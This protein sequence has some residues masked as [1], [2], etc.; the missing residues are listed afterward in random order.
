MFAIVALALT[1]VVVAATRADGRAGSQSASNDGG[2]W[3][4]NRDAGAVGHLNREVLEVSA[5]VRVAEVGA[6]FDID[7]SNDLI[8][9]HDRSVEQVM[10]LD[11][12]T[13]QIRQT[14]AV[15]PDVEVSATDGGVV[16][17]RTSP[18]EVWQLA[19]DEFGAIDDVRDLPPVIT[20]TSGLIAVGEGVTA[21]FDSETSSVIRFT[22][23]FEVGRTRIEGTPSSIGIVGGNAV[24]ATDDDIIEVESGR[25]HSPGTGPYTFAQATP[26]NSIVAVDATDE[27]FVIDPDGSTHSFT[28]ASPTTSPILHE[29][30]VFAITE[31]PTLVR[32]CHPGDSPDGDE[33]QMPL[34]GAIGEL[35]LR[36]VNGWIWVNDLDTGGAW[37]TNADAPLSRIDDW[38][39]ALAEDEIDESDA[40]VEDEGGI[41]EVRLNPD[42]DD[43]Q[44]I[45]ADQQDDDDEND[46]PVARDDKAST[47]VDRPVVVRVL[48]NDEDPDG[49]VLLVDSVEV[50][51]TSTAQVWITSTRDTIQVTP[52]AG[53][54]GTVEFSYLVTDGRGG[55]DR[56]TVVVD[57]TTPSASTNRP[58]EPVTDVATARA[59]SA[60]S[61]NVLTNDTD[62]DGDA[63][64]LLEV[65]AERGHIVFDPSGQVTFTPDSADGQGRIE[66]GYLVSDDFGA[67]AEGRIVVNVR[68]ADANST[69]DARNDSVVT[70]VDNP[71]R[72]N[73]LD[74]DSDPDG[75][76]LIVARQPILT[77]GPNGVSGETIAASVQ[78][79]RDGEFSFV[80]EIA[81]VYLFDYL[82]SDGQNSDTAQIRVDVTDA[83]VN[84]PPVAVRDDVSIPVGGTRLVYVL[85]NDGDPNGDVIDIVEWS[86]AQG[87]DIEPVS[88]V[89]FRVTVGTDAPS[90]STFRY[91]ISDGI[92]EPVATVV[93]VSV[94]DV[95]S[96]NQ[97][98]IVRPD[99]VELR[100][101]RSTTIPVLLNDFDPEGGSLSV[102]RLPA[103]TDDVTYELGPDGQS[104]IVTLA[105]TAAAGFQFGYDVIDTGGATAASIVD[106][107]VI[108]STE[109]NRPP[110][111]RP[112]IGRTVQ[113]RSIS[114]A[115]L[116]NDTDPDGDVVTIESIA[117]QPRNGVA[118]IVDGG[119]LYTPSD[120]FTGTDRFTYVVIDT[121]GARSIGS[122][123]VG[124]TPAARQN[125]APSANDDRIV[126]TTTADL[127]VL[128]NDH[129]P[130]GDALTLVSHTEPS[131][132][133][134]DRRGNSL[135]YTPPVVT[136]TT[137]VSFGYE[138]SDG[139]GNTDS[140]TVLV[141]VE[142]EP[143][144]MPPQA[145]DDTSGP[146]R[147]NREVVVDVLANDIDPDGETSDLTL[148]T[149]D[150]SA[151]VSGGR[152]VLTVG[153]D[154]TQVRYRIEDA[155]GLTD[156]ATVTVLVVENEAPII[157]TL[158]TET[159]HDRPILLDLSRQVTDPDDDALFFACCD[160]VIGGVADVVTSSDGRL[161]VSFTP[162]PGYSGDA[163][164]SFGADDQAG[165]LVSGSVIVVVA[166]PD[167]RPPTAV[168][169]SVEIEAGS[170]IPFDLAS[171][172]EDPDDDPLRF[173]LDSNP[174]G[175]T[176]TGS[177]VTLRAPVDA[178]G[179]TETVQF[180]TTDP[181]G[182]SIASSLAVSVT[183]VSAPPPRAIADA[184]T[185][186]QGASVSIDLLTN[187]LDP[188]G[189]GLDIFAVGS[190]PKGTTVLEGRSVLFTPNPDVFGT[191]TFTY[192]IRDAANSS[193][194][195]S[196]GQ[197]TVE[198]IGRPGTA[199]TPAANADNASATVTW[200]APAQN[201]AAIDTY[202]IETRTADGTS[203]I[204]LGAQNSHT[205]TGL[206]NGIDH[207]FRVQA[208]NVAGWG[209][210]SSWSAPVRPN[211]IADR[212]AAPLATFGNGELSVTWTPPANEGS[213][214]TGYQIE[215]GGGINQVIAVGS[216]P[217][218]WSGLANGTEYQFRIAAVNE[219]GNSD[220]SGW[221]TSEH[222]LTAPAAPGAPAVGRGNRYLDI[223]WSA[224]VDNGDPVSAYEVQIQSTNQIVPI[225]GASTT[226]LR[227]ADLANGE[228]QQFRVR[229]ANR[230]P[231]PGAWS[232]WS[233]P[234]VPCAVPDAASAPTV[235][236]GDGQVAV[237]WTTPGD[238]GCAISSYEIRANGSTIQT[239]GVTTSHTFT[240]L[241]NGTSYTFE[242]RATNEE[243]PGSWS[244]LSAAVIPAGP[245]TPP[246]ISSVAPTA[247]GQLTAAWSG[248][249][250]NGSP[251]S[252]H[253][254]SINGGSPITAGATG[255]TVTGLADSTSYDLRVRACNEVGCSGYSATVSATTWGPPGAPVGVN[256]SAGDAVGQVN[257]STP[258]SNG[259]NAITTYRVSLS[260][261]SS[262]DLGAAS[263]SR[264]FSGLANDTT[265]TATV[266]ACNAVGCGPTA[267]TSFTPTRPPV[268][269]TLTRGGTYTG[270]NCASGNCQYMHI[271]GRNL[272]PS[273]TVS[274]SCY[275]SQDDR[276]K[277][278]NLTT[279]SSGSISA[280]PCHMGFPGRQVWASV[281]DPVRGQ[282]LSNTLT[283]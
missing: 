40:T 242:V 47:R 239:T 75:D 151:R 88:G 86:G 260:D 235:T 46:P 186:N 102:I 240:G 232:A 246:S 209:E 29:G 237:S 220:W 105:P 142:P 35:R 128:S 23:G 122:V 85:D 251:I 130:D 65:T 107:R 104:I 204:D 212:P 62:P 110:I 68:L 276:F 156:E 262:A 216:S 124:V 198:I 114:I 192:T 264:S 167:N 4:L 80:P 168:N 25:S 76:A 66:A 73:V 58:P 176:I 123:Q 257:W 143:E 74:N 199:A 33:T 131:A 266:A 41:E 34:D 144:P 160:N 158:R 261:G 99:T 22:D 207:E 113:A 185:T 184:A 78:M 103:S 224:P 189:D 42:A 7:Q 231:N 173:T 163:S 252:R 263:R 255:R 279:D 64:V 244:S 36:L 48:D 16:I 256:A 82:A 57:V 203:S 27:V 2:A 226:D 165:H 170:S 92:A 219:A 70:S 100:P 93:V 164:F 254:L 137:E 112:D 133:T 87:L 3:L 1:G 24:V 83:D 60:T 121:E 201:G 91:A 162:S 174:L 53:F 277:T 271:E 61:L 191:T 282:T 223:D 217:Y 71:A 228:A 95:A 84:L 148:M 221:S 206:A 208:H 39:A 132:G 183:P 259:G 153:Q 138:I 108:S 51:E 26:S 30:C 272:T 225:A 245:P 11:G 188:L 215:I 19:A 161:E 38:G 126:V 81:G 10:L 178:A 147:G 52:A 56:A 28:L 236:R 200:S 258:S 127:D 115:V 18:L 247:I 94:A 44:L 169:G 227:W 265:Y 63:L 152:L 202:R 31:P 155:D 101:G 116:A 136:E 195:E 49:D 69:P 72:T 135:V 171:L 140:A 274:L 181:T 180:T 177:V 106:V 77:V 157:T 175:A 278:V 273:S 267:S 97:P 218:V 45:D 234:V 119:V 146:V 37:V 79:T 172:V 229:A 270:A 194:R 182:A 166:P 67:T 8:V 5:G 214:I 275:D 150:P 193:D 9:L 145:L 268:T 249:G 90:R 117:T 243:G 59:G 238:Q 129:D 111:A 96:T 6:D 120:S 98:P 196:V 43:V 230:D 187:D 12:R 139:H 32:H 125:R 149:L 15:P 89:G 55:S 54:E 134:I 154:S 248:A 20:G 222:P 14:V 17:H 210:W 211:T 141:L 197:V 205:F 13:N 21:V 179:S 250:A 118:E 280:N 253:E 159:A 241:T 213:P 109:P 50:P 190:S 233:S 283:W 269:L 281:S